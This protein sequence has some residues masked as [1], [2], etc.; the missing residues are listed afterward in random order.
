MAQIT[1]ANLQ[2]WLD[3]LATI[4]GLYI[5]DPN[6][7]LSPNAY[8]AAPGAGLGQVGGNAKI[9]GFN[10][11]IDG[12]ADADQLS[13]LAPA[14][15]DLNTFNPSIASALASIFGRELAAIDA[16]LARFVQPTASMLNLLD[17]YLTSINGAQGQTPTLRA[18]Q[19]FSVFLKALS[20]QNVFIASSPDLA[21]FAI[22]GAAAG[23]QSLLTSGAGTILPITAGAL[24]KSVAGHQFLI[25]NTTAL[26]SGPTIQVTATTVQGTS[27][28]LS[29]TVTN[30]ANGAATNLSD[31]SR[32][33]IAVT[34]VSISAGG[35]SGNSFKV[36]A[37]SDR[38][39]DNV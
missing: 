11:F 21:T 18:H 23:T 24:P 39:I 10:T 33:Y 4:A 22:T 37:V 16:H 8:G 17:A 2:T 5:G 12:L 15:R 38:R 25:I 34:A 1:N 19:Y 9:A 20:A 29:V 30:L 3:K 26:T 27:V 6:L 35:T 32:L 31:T 13:D 36:T 28:V 14:A 7:N